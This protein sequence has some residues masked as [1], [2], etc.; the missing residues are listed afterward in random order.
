MAKKV[1]AIAKQTIHGSYGLATEGQEIVLDEKHAKQLEKRG[2]IE[3]TG[4]TDDE[5]TTKKEGSFSITDNTG[6]PKEKAEQDTDAKNPTG[7]KNKNAGPGSNEKNS[8]AGPDRIKAS[9]LVD[10][11]KGAQ[12]AKEVD[13]LVGDDDRATV[14]AAAEKKKEEFKK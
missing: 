8:D 10:I 12:S 9:E 11:I 1:T 13:E 6:K 14:L 2:A 7:E 3:I 4:E 5:P